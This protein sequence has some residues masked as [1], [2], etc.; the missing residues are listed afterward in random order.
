MPEEQW[1]LYIFH[2]KYNVKKTKIL[3]DLKICFYNILF[4]F[5]NDTHNF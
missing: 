1:C 5:N 4:K 2:K 3:N